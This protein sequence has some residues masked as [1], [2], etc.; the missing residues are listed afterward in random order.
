MPKRG[1]HAP[2]AWVL[3][4][5]AEHELEAPR[6]YQPTNAL[7][8]VVAEQS[9][10]LLSTLV[11]PGDVVLDD[12]DLSNGARRAAGMRGAAWLPTPRALR[13]LAAAGAVGCESPGLEVLQRVNRRDFGARLREEFREGAFEKHIVHD[14]EAALSI[15]ARPAPLGWLARRSFGAAGRGRRKLRA[16]RPDEAER[17]WLVASLRLGPLVVEPW[18]E[19]AREH[20]RSGWVRSDGGVLVSAPCF[21]RTTA[22]GAW[23]AT[24]R[25]ERGELS[26]ELDKRLAHALERVGR[27]LAAEGYHGPYGID[28]WSYREGGREVL[29]PLSEVNA[30]FTMDWATAMVHDPRDGDA[31]RVLDELAP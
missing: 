5:D 4:L 20:T 6:G 13:I 17:A 8:A 27:A 2:R 7:R 19:I 24:A 22:S 1:E 28:A 31:R 15:L 23:I 16:G 12:G 11:R 26:S 10:R 14:L 30:R 18:Q 29:N 9:R 21:Q 25:A 3:N